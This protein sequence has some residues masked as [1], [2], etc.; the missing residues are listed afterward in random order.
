MQ[1]VSPAIY[2]GVGVDEVP[3]A[4][5]VERRS[6]SVKPRRLTRAVAKAR[7][8]IHDIGRIDEDRVGKVLVAV[9]GHD[10]KVRAVNPIADRH[11]GAL[12]VNGVGRLDRDPPLAANKNLGAA[13][14]SLDELARRR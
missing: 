1:R 6:G 5:V 11:V 7:I 9:F 13:P 12:R 2:A 4:D 10:K 14:V 8:V 3:A